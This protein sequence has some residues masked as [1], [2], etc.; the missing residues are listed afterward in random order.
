MID[1]MLIDP[2]FYVC[3]AILVQLGW[4]LLLLCRDKRRDEFIDMIMNRMSDL[5]K[6]PRGRC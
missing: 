6:P 2:L 1:F 5:K 4:V 3:G